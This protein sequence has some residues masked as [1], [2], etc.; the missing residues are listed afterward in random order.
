[1]TWMADSFPTMEWLVRIAVPFDYQMSK[2]AI[3]SSVGKGHVVVRREATARRNMIALAL[4]SSLRSQGAT[5][6]QN[7][8][9]VDIM[10]EKP[11]HRG[12]A[13]N[14]V[15]LVCDAIKDA[16]MLDDRW[17]SIRRLDWRVVK[18][19]PRILIGIGQEEG[20]VDSLV[21]SRCGRILALESFTKNKSG[22]LGRS[23]NCLECSRAT[24]QRRRDSKRVAAQG[25]PAR[26][27]VEISA[28]EEVAP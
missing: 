24:D 10:V 7:R 22:P 8:L 9:W 14:V 20:A 16:T 2:N 15:D 28:L 13:V 21:C 4:K 26:V 6:V 23:R 17:Y 11:N 1:M 5:I 25:E 27:V 18:K 3:W 19:N 12:D